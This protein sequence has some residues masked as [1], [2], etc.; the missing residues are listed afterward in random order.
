MA[1]SSERLRGA[2][3]R[4]CP[5][6]NAPNRPSGFRSSCPAW[7][8]RA[9][10]DVLAELD[11]EA[12]LRELVEGGVEFLLIGGVAVA[13]HGYVRATKDVDVVPA[14]DRNNLE[15]LAMVLQHLEAQVEG[16]EDFDKGELPDPLDPAALELGG[17]WILSTRLGR[18]DVMQWIGDH[19]L[20]GELS[21]AAIE[22]RIDGLPVKIVGYEDLVKLKELAGRPEDLLDLQHLREARES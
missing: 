22:E 10:A 6:R 14:S 1:R 19:E 8:T 12:L 9:A 3:S 21:P 17:N 18:L 16:A 5:Q 11:I 20:W 7:R 13:Y 4:S 15:R 2:T